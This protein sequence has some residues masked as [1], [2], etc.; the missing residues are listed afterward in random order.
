M[1]KHT[2]VAKHV[3][4]RIGVL[5]ALALLLLLLAAGAAFAWTAVNLQPVK[6]AEDQFYNYDFTA[7][8]VSATGVDW[9]VTI[10]F[11]GNASVSK[12]KKAYQIRGWSN[13]FVTT[14][15]GYLNDGAGFGFAGDGGVKMFATKTPHMRLYA[16]G[17]RMY[18]AAWGYYVVATTH[19]DNAEL[20]APP[21]QW[22]GKSEEAATVAVQTAV[23]A[24]GAKNVTVNTLAL[25]NAQYG[26]EVGANGERHIWQCD[27]MATMVKVP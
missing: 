25:D 8:T 17:G 13:P 26:E 6:S 2:A 9:S 21:T 3:L 5:S 4:S 23:T 7:K 16:P 18:N 14:M 1:T 12:I 10:V 22:F 19:F 15:Y 27:G 11:Y 24:W 20:K